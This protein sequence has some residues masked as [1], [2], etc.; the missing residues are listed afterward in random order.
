MWLV[1]A[2]VCVCMYACM[3]VW[4]CAH[5][6]CMCVWGF[7]HNLVERNLLHFLFVAHAPLHSTPHSL[8]SYITTSYLCEF[9]QDLRVMAAAA[10]ASI[11]FPTPQVTV[12]DLD[13]V[14]HPLS[15]MSLL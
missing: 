14:V 10:P 9:L 13:Q 8:L 11:V 15:R 4:M 3:H 2:C 6:V 5:M 12:H 7:T 1:C